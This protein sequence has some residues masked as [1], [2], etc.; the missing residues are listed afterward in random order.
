MPRGSLDVRQ[1]EMIER[2]SFVDYL[3]AGWGISL[4]VAIDFTASNGAPSTPSSLHYLGGFNQYEAAINGV[5]PV[6]EPYDADQKFPTFGFG[7][8]PRHMG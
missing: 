7:G 1:F 8:I 3:R 6:I 2:P 4:A 5:G